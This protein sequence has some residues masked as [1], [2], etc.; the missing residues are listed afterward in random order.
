MD[1]ILWCNLSNE[2]CRAILSHGTIYYIHK[3]VLFFESVDTILFQCGL[4]FGQSIETFSALLS[5]GNTKNKFLGFFPLN[6]PSFL[7]KINPSNQRE[8]E[9]SHGNISVPF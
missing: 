7:R 8:L 9:C 6:S 3:Q 4:G 5:L 2:T 1:A